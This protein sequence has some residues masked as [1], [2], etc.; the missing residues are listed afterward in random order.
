MIRC[1]NR[2]AGALLDR[3]GAGEAV[4]L[5]R[6]PWHSGLFSGERHLVRL[7]FEGN[8][9]HGNASRLIAR[10]GDYEFDLPGCLVADLA[11]TGAFAWSGRAC[12]EVEALVI[13]ES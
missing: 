8:D 3:T 6:E 4:P 9:A 1:E 5:R 7:V 12:V 13:D 11:V 2:L 10:L